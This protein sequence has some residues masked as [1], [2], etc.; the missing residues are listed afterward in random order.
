MQVLFSIVMALVTLGILVTIHEYGHYWVARR[1]G[2]R[3]LRFAVGFGRPLAMRVDRHGTEF[4]LCAIPLGGYVK[5]LDERDEGQDVTAENRHESFNAQ[6]VRNK[7]AIV[8]AGPAA[9]FLLAILVLFG[10]FLR[11][12][13][14][15]APVIEAVEPGSVA[16]DMG[17]MQGQE[18]VAVDGTSTQTVSNVRFA[19]LKRLGDTGTIDISVG[20]ALSDLQQTY[21]LPID[22]WLGGAEAPDPTRALG[23]TLGIPPLQPSVGSLVEGGPATRAGFEVGDTIIEA[24]GQAIST[25]S[26]WV[27]LVRAS[28]GRSIAV[29]VERDGQTIELTVVPRSTG[30][31]DAEVGSV[32]MGVVIP[33]VPEDRIRR[34]GRN[35]VEALSAAIE[36]T[37]ALTV[38][39]FESMWKM[40]QGLISTKNLSGPIAIAQVAASTAESGFTTWLSFLAL[41]S[42]SLGAIN[43]LPIPVLDGG[44]IVFHSLEGLL[45]RP[46]P[47][48]IQIMSYQV[49][50]LAVFTLMVFAIYNDVARL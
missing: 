48:Q 29:L 47:E 8:S 24:D 20:N 33:D 42:I 15:I 22:R 43:L 12:E 1:C 16:H 31:S 3:V 49:G 2:V 23:L 39:T 41:L 38:F 5:M 9:N 36:R 14:G 45:G 40:I 21:A 13:T 6:P 7:L 26:Q 30:T 32:G 18:I 4:A 46:V 17:L 27:D 35:P 10:L 25:W 50:L 34:Q 37:F 44:H 28:P 19:L 11:G